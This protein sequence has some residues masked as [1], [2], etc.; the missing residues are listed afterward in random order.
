MESTGPLHLYVG[1]LS[2]YIVLLLPFLGALLILSHSRIQVGLLLVVVAAAIYLL[3]ET[4]NRIAPF[5]VSTAVLTYSALLFLGNRRE[6]K[7]TI[8]A[9]AVAALIVSAGLA[10]VLLKERTPTGQTM[11]SGLSID[12]RV[13][14]WRTALGN[15]AQEP[16]SGG[17]YGLRAFALRNPAVS[18]SDGNYWHAHNPLLNRG[19][20]MGWPGIAAFVVL[21]A[22]TIVT[23]LRTWSRS[24]S[25]PDRIFAAAALA[26][27]AAI[28]VKN[29]TD[30]F[31]VRQFNWLYWVLLACALGPTLT[32]RMAR[33]HKIAAHTP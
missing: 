18:A 12:P 24:I 6:V 27:T 10:A 28:I 19:V 26:S 7:R 31:M 32:R 4:G 23:L 22:A 1:E 30:D 20:Q 21:Y 3:Y 5:A 25:R 15:L 11:L 2:T 9:G 17:G 13:M 14:L 29:L 33:P 16:W 8:V